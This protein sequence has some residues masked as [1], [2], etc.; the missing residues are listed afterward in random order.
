MKD[1]AFNI[2]KRLVKVEC[3]LK[4]AM[5]KYKDLEARSRHN[6]L[7]FMSVANMG[8]Q[9]IFVEKLLTK[10]F[11]QQD[12]TDTSVVGT[13]YL[14]MAAAE[15]EAVMELLCHV[16]ETDKIKA[17]VKHSTRGAL[18]AGA[19]A[20]MGGLVGGP[21]GIAVGIKCLCGTHLYLDLQVGHLL[22]H[23]DPFSEDLEELITPMKTIWGKLQWSCSGRVTWFLDYERP[24]ARHKD[25]AKSHFICRTNTVL[26]WD[27]TIDTSSSCF[28]TGALRGS[29]GNLHAAGPAPSARL[30]TVRWP[31]T[32]THFAVHYPA[33]GLPHAVPCVLHVTAQWQALVRSPARPASFTFSIACA[34]AVCREG[35]AA[36]GGYL[37]FWMARGQFEP[38]PQIIRAMNES[39]KQKLYAEIVPMVEKLT[40]STA[41]QLITLV[42]GI[43]TLKQSVAAAL[44]NFV[45][46][47]LKA[48][49][50]YGD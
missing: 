28:I 33:A 1:D 2:T 6:N 21:P 22:S 36:V 18:Y 49:I 13:F 7:R 15:V 14:T 35:C 4:T 17:A 34:H 25:V 26:L 9:D 31:A 16:A 12:F 44:I 39:E 5:A 45:K 30:L 20:F 46:H 50:K 11:S 8:H 24:L 37:V 32:C 40:W 41:T 19:A 42:M 10:L 23:W 48:Q 43:P 27:P 29:T 3:L 47:E 38:L